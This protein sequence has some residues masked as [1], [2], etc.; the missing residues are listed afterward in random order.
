MHREPDIVIVG[1][2]IAG[3]ALACGLRRRG[4]EIV[5]IE[6]SGGPLDTAR[7]DHLQPRTS[8]ILDRWRALDAFFE[9]GAEKRLGGRWLTAQGDEVFNVSVDDLPIPNP[10]HLYLDHER[11]SETFLSLA[12]EN[13]DFSLQRPVKAK[14]TVSR[15][16][17]PHVVVRQADGAEVVLRPKIL[18]GADGRGSAVRKALNLPARIHD[19]ENPLVVLFA[20]RTFE[21]ERNDVWSYLGRGE[22]VT[23]IPRT[24]KK[25]KIGVRIDKSEIAWWKAS[26]PKDRA[27]L[28]KDAVPAVGPL[29]TEIAG[30]YPIK[31]LTAADWVAGNAVL[32]GDACHALHPG[33]SQG[34]N[35]AIRCIDALID[36]LPPPDELRD[37]RAVHR[38]LNRYQRSCKPEV[39][40]I[41]DENHKSGRD[42]DLIDE[43]SMPAYI[44]SFRALARDEDSSFRYRMKAAGYAA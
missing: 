6:Q 2:G 16:G 11:I 5:L 42:M 30:F 28:L 37:S 33:R 7:G 15:G 25:W 32:I 36:H 8:E 38:A 18:V 26:T 21:D 14:V 13:D 1:G 19:Y 40:R 4:Y 24:G 43:D 41:L 10:Y 35:V 17:R 34:M 12:R 23:L 22:I 9:R 39:D 44:E 3:P 31:M 29:E 20:P 27:V